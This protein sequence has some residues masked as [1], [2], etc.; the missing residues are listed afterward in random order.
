LVNLNRRR[1]VNLS[2]VCRTSS[3][4]AQA[5]ASIEGVITKKLDEVDFVG[6]QQGFVKLKNSGAQ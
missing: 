1:L 2:G 6:L 4:P 3:D 5:R